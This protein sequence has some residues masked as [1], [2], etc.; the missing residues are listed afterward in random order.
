MQAIDPDLPDVNGRNAGRSEE[1]EKKWIMVKTLVVRRRL[2]DVN[3]LSYGQ[4]EPAMKGAH[5]NP[6]LFS[7]Y[8]KSGMGWEV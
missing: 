8:A 2:S 4:V 5:S 6:F 7:F 3:P 1:S